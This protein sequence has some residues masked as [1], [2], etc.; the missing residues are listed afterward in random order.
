MNAIICLSGG[1]ASG[2]TTIAQALADAWPNSSIRS[3]GDVVR[4]QARA[5]RLG[6]DRATLQ[7]T[8]IRLIAEGWP[9]FVDALIADIPPQAELLIVDG[10]RHVEPVHELRR[11]FPTIPVRLAFLAANETS[12]QQRMAQCGEPYNALGHAVESELQRVAKAADILI[13]STWPPGEI[14]AKIR[15]LAIS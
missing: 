5:D 12:V 11:Q 8:G 15:A 7:E 3:F 13:D 1:I 6:T 2:K 4:A 9:A 14:V 10:V